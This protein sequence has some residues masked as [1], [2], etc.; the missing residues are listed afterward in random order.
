[1]FAAEDDSEVLCAAH[2]RVDKLTA[3]LASLTARTEQ[4]RVERDTLDAPIR[5]LQIAAEGGH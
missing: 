1:M 4:A 3:E 5:E 2:A